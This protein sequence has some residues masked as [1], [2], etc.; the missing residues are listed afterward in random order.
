MGRRRRSLL[1]SRGSSPRLDDVWTADMEEAFHQKGGQGGASGT[2][3]APPNL[4]DEPSD[5]EVPIAALSPAPLRFSAGTVP[6]SM[7]ESFPGLTP[8]SAGSTAYP[9]PV[10]ASGHASGPGAGG[11]TQF[12]HVLRGSFAQDGM[13]PLSVDDA[14]RRDARIPSPAPD[15]EP[16][17]SGQVHSL[18]GYERP[19]Q[20]V[21]APVA[22][23]LFGDGPGFEEF[24][25][26]SPPTD[27]FQSSQLLEDVG[28]PY[29]TPYT[30][31]EPPPIPG[32]LDRFTPPPAQRTEIG[33]RRK[34][35]EY[36][37]ETP[38]AK[39]RYE[40]T[41]SPERRKIAPRTE[42]KL[43]EEPP[44]MSPLALLIGIGSVLL[45]VMGLVTLVI[46]LM[47]AF[48]SRGNDEDNS[49]NREPVSGG[50][51]IR[52]NVGD[53]A[54]DGDGTPASNELTVPEREVAPEPEIDPSVPVP[55]I[56][57]PKL[58]ALPAPTPEPPPP[59]V[60]V[61]PPEPPKAIDKGTLKIRSNRRVLIY[62][63]GQAIGYTP[64]EFQGP[65]GTYTVLAMVPGQPNTKQSRE[66]TI[67]AEHPLLGV[68]FSF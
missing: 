14:L 7:P 40:P 31:P 15:L 56:G 64:Q 9:A 61:P 68:D 26:S 23:D 11:Q 2:G 60:P 8:G 45:V 35:P 22:S 41:P 58:P 48:S 27:E 18:A 53:P 12:E 38:Q 4:D 20:A 10:H 47:I 51:E 66:V 37:A 62:V 5:I 67:D 39:A 25:K 34:K 57:P 28:Q 30:V 43:R 46:A 55:V 65:P 32:I 36:L 17:P 44:G 42:E 24:E 63:N 21:D 59:V 19:R 52:D 13:A 50:V 33:S 29:A 16:S 49:L 3:G 1:E 54:T 6:S